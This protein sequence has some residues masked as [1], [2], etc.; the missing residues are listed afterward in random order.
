MSDFSSLPD[1][2]QDSP[3]CPVPTWALRPLAIVLPLAALVVL[4]WIIFR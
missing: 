1:D 3:R 2:E 4:L